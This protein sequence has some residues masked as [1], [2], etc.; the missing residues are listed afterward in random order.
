MGRCRII[1][2]ER[3]FLIILEFQY[4]L[5]VIFFNTRTTLNQ[6]KICRNSFIK[7]GKVETISNPDN[8]S[9][10]IPPTA[11]DVYTIS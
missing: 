7:A 5:A 2:S 4:E 8:I 10:S 11:D 6:H 3:R 1:K 9:A